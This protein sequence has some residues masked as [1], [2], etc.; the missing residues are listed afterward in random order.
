MNDAATVS[1]SDRPSSGGLVRSFPQSFRASDSRLFRSYV[2]VAGILG[3]L[4]SLLLTFA[5]IVWFFSTLGSSALVTT[6]NALLGVVA[7]FVLGPLFAPVLLVARRYRRGT[8]DVRYDQRLALAGYLFVASLY[9]GLVISVPSGQQE[10][11][12]GL[13]APLVEF[14]YGLPQIA[15][16][17]PPVIAAALLWAVHGRSR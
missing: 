17:V 12:S 1:E 5:L 13:L 10:S 2:V 7:V 16:V 14:L 6:S 9:V 4:L 3:L 8:S 15:G 11:V